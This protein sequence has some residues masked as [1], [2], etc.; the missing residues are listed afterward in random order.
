MH[1]LFRTMLPLVI[2]A[3]VSLGGCNAKPAADPEL[4]AKY[5]K[6]LTL[7]EEPDG[8]ETVLDVRSRLLGEEAPDVL[9]M[10]EEEHDHGDHEH[11]A[12]HAHESDL[13]HADHEHADEATGGEEADHDHAAEEHA[14][15]EHADHDHAAEEHEHGDHDHSDD[16]H[17][18]HDHAEHESESEEVVLVGL[19]GGVPNPF[20]QGTPDFPFT[21]GQAMFFLADPEAVAELEEHGHQHA[22]GEECAFCLANAADAAQLIAGVTF[23]DEKGKVLAVDARDLFDLKSKDAVVIK[24]T[25]KMV[26]GSEFL[27]VQATGLYVRR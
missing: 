23:V 18:G 26:P 4:V 5:R 10:L 12:E 11:A 6:Q 20:K 24:G 14:E 3:L 21:K 16:D 22:P 25:A 8:A 27:Q 7:A 13:E 2:P 19:V 1:S 15:G 17:K 9:A